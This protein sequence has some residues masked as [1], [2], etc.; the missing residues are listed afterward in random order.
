MCMWHSILLALS[1]VTYVLIGWFKFLLLKFLYEYGPKFL[2]STWFQYLER[3]DLAPVFSEE[4]F[5][6]WFICRK[7]IIESFVVEVSNNDDH[8]ATVNHDHL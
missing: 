7:G 4:D 8:S 2:L 3:M 6:H 1:D 5:R